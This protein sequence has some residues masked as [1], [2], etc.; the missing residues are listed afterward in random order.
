MDQLLEMG[1]RQ[2]NQP[3]GMGKHQEGQPT[4]IGK[5]QEDQPTGM[6]KRQA[7]STGF[8]RLKAK[9]WVEGGG[10]GG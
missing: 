5:R 9:V 8:L 3:T 7:K 6:G 1:K 10:R 4:G 2:V